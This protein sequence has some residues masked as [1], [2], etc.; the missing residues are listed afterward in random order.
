MHAHTAFLCKLSLPSYCTA[1]VR[2]I[3]WDKIW[4]KRTRARAHSLLVQA[5]VAIIL[6]IRRAYIK[7][8]GA[9]EACRR[10]DARTHSPLVQAISV[11][12]AKCSIMGAGDT[13]M[14]T[15]PKWPLP[16]H[17]P[18]VAVMNCVIQL[19]NILLLFG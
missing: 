18:L 2:T 4:V 19:F 5:V 12:H 9:K 6:Y 14:R 7:K 16:C 3:R 1:G 17:A 10:V 15:C 11:M 8:L 13:S